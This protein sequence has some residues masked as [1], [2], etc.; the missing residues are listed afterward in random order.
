MRTI[1]KFVLLFFVPFAA[2]KAQMN[3]SFTPATNT[4][5]SI[6]GTTPILTGNNND[7]IADEGFVNAIPIGFSFTYNGGTSYT[8]VAISTNGFISFGTLSDSY[9]TNNLTSGASGQRPIIAPLWDDMNLQTTN[10]LKYTTTGTAPNRVF[11]VEWLNT[12]WGFG[13]SA[14]CISFQVKLYETTNWIEFAYRQES[15]TP[16]SPSASVGL[17]ATGT[18]NN[19]F[20]SLGNVTSTPNVSTTAETST[21]NTKPATNQ[22]YIFKPGTL[23]VS[24]SSFSV[25]REKNNHV[26]QWQTANEINNAFFEIER[27]ANGIQFSSIA[28]QQSKAVLGNSTTLLQYS[29]DDKNPLSGINYYRLKQVD[30]D[31][32]IMYSSIISIKN[33]QSAN[34]SISLFPNPVKNKLNIQLNNLNATDVTVGIYNI[35]GQLVTQSKSSVIQSNILAIDVTSLTTG[36]YTI[37]VFDTKSNSYLTERFVK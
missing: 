32:K 21:I 7:P 27:S 12:R 15:G 30:K 20:I 4:Y 2:V 10:N 1:L 24:I 25:V 19:N 13:A 36:I 5:S 31:G 37:R 22:S 34:A 11:T 18:G 6:S 29:I 16:V 23:P 3:Y 26:V 17:T 28:Q 35:Y 8:E 9:V 33:S 14:A